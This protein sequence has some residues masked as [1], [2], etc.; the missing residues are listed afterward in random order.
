RVYPPE[1]EV[2]LAASYAG[3]EEKKQVS[4]QPVSTTDELGVVNLNKKIGKANGVLAYCTT[5]YYSDK[6]QE[7]QFRL[8]SKNATKLW[9]N[10]KLIDQHEVYHA[11]GALDQ[12]V[13]SA[14]LVAGKN[15]ILLK[16]CQ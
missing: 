15:V 11:G 8:T 10:G 5:D 3:A 14:K 7:V 9:V 1:K 13:S 4:W 16:V 6:A 2:D 12:Y